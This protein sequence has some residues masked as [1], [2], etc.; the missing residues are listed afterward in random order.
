MDEW[1]LSWNLAR[2]RVY[3]QSTA[4]KLPFIP[5]WDCDEEKLKH[6]MKMKL[7]SLNYFHLFMWGDE[8]LNAVSSRRITQVEM[9]FVSWHEYAASTTSVWCGANE[10]F[11][12]HPYVYFH[13]LLYPVAVSAALYTCASVWKTWKTTEQP[14]SFHWDDTTPRFYRTHHASGRDEH[15]ID[16]HTEQSGSMFIHRTQK[17]H[18]DDES[19]HRASSRSRQADI[20]MFETLHNE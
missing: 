16:K 18:D 9:T 19:T 14:Y 7:S 3:I 4:V 8:L 20:F 17:R 5:G 2:T 15:D 1:Y 6:V 11:L 10:T 13:G 12:F